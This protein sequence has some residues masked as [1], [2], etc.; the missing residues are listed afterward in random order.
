MIPLRLRHPSLRYIIDAFD[1]SDIT[2]NAILYLPL[3][4]ALG[5][6]SLKRAFLFG[7]CLST[8]AETLQLG[9]VDRIPSFVDIATN[10][11]GAVAGYLLARLWVPAGA[12]PTLRLPRPVTMVAIPV[13]ILG[14]L[15]LAHARPTSDFSNWNSTFHL[16]VGNELNGMRPWAGTV[17]EFVVYPFAM[18]TSQISGIAHQGETSAGA[19]AGPMREADLAKRFGDSL[20]SR[21]QEVKLYDALVGANR[22]TLLVWM[23]T[24]NLEQSGAARVVTYSQ[25]LLNRNFTLAQVRNTLTFRVRTPA[26]GGNG[27]DPALFSG[28]VLSANKTSFVAAVYDGRISRLYVD[29]KDVA[30]TDLGAKR[31]RLPK[32]ILSWLPGSIPIR[33]IELVGAEI[34]LSGLFAI[35]V[36]GLVG[37]PD[38]LMIR[39]FVGAMAGGA[40]GGMTWAFA[41]SEVGLGI[42]ILVECV[43]AGLVVAASVERGGS[44]WIQLVVK[45]TAGPSAPVGKTKGSGVVERTAGP[46]VGILWLVCGI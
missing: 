12:S 25:D 19:V 3:G 17:A 6:S 7:L 20:L 10:T 37:V 8:C 40:I 38:R 45:E 1:L 16:A 15:G 30:H 21:E 23:R 13:A 32:R 33:E 41:V 36:F 42:R 34:L 29:G 11:S 9:F 31:P 24:D 5:G 39:F 27:T 28:P 26:S 43:A 22:M 18:S 4:I 35:G 14:S 2:N 44:S 46:V